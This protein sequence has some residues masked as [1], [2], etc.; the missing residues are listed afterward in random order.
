MIRL[1]PGYDPA[2]VADIQ[3]A[4]L[5]LNCPGT[6]RY[7]IGD[8]LGLREGN[9]NFA[10]VADFTDETAYRGYDLDAAHNAARARLAPLAEQTAR[11]QF[12]VDG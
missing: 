2:E 7:T 6:I 1:K 11:V 3:Q 5:N 8:D 10:I 9:W 12:L 4:F